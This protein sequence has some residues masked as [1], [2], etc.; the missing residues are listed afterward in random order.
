VAYKLGFSSHSYFSSHFKEYFGT[1][2][3]EFVAKYTKPENH[4]DFEDL[5]R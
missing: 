5:V 3:T 1:S 4:E 2:P